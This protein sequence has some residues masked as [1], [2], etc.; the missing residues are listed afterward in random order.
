MANV[1]INRKLF[2]KEIGKLDEKMQDKISLMGTP[3]YN[4]NEDEIEIEIYPNRP[5]LLSYQ[6]FKRAFLSFLGKEKG[7]KEY[8]TLPPKKDY[9]VI[10]DSSVKEVRP[11]TACAIVTN[12]KLD[13][14]KIKEII[15]MQEKLHLT[16]GRKRKKMALG[17]YPL[18]KIKLPITF[19]ALE[20]E[21]IRFMALGAEKEMSGLEILQKHPT[22]KE[23]SHLLA[24]KAK[25][26]IFLD[27]ENKILS[28]PP[29]INSQ[30]TGK[31]GVNT[32]DVFIECSGF[33]SFSLSK[34]LNIVVT[35]LADM[36]GNIYQMD[37]KYAKKE[38][39]PNLNPEKM[40]L[41][42]SNANK[43]LGL[44]LKEKE[45][46]ELLEKM[47]HNYQKGYVEIPSWRMDI[48]HE[49]DLIEDIAI[50]YGYNNFEEVIPEISTIGQE[51]KK[52]T[53]KR[54][55]AEILAG[56]GILEISNYHLTNKSDQFSKMGIQERQ[57][58]DFIEIL[59]SKTE[60]NILRKD[61][62]HYL[63][64][65]LSENVDSEYPH[66]IFEQG[67]VFGSLNNKVVEKESLSIALSPANFTEIRQALE[68]LSRMLG[69][70]I[71]L[72]E[73]KFNLEQYIDGRVVEI[74]FDGKPIGYLGEIHPKILKNW[75]IRM[76]VALL[77]ISLEEIF[78]RLV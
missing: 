41:S 53:L 2:E 46:K 25:F 76:P 44:S 35:A 47:G 13:D 16:L 45:I 36:G 34:C 18:E 33:D 3:I 8:K 77:E 73:P 72:K 66:R 68:Y 50:A 21:K 19:K 69:I 10:I 5:D 57:L 54:K 17:I 65:I 1:K 70:E 38:I 42:I 32:K 39:T 58:K 12:L 31:I 59:E 63:L 40:K 27:R 15:D 52:E 62:S 28:M 9:Q 7:I 11:Y 64:K 71:A 51:D 61:L 56:L 67:K 43:L 74:I 75:R 4:L 14:E 48:M 6:G 26:P 55:I 30:T 20:P 24:G 78:K 29:I 23:Y 49:V 22:G 37:L 60:Y